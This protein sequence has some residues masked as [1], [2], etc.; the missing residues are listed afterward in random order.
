MRILF[1]IILPVLIFTGLSAREMESFNTGWNFQLDPSQPH[2]VIQSGLDNGTSRQVDLPHDWS[3]EGPYDKDNPA[4]IR[5][6]FLP[7]GIGFYSKSFFW[8]DGW[9]G[10]R[11]FIEFDGVFMKSDVWINGVHLGYY[12][13][14]YMGFSYDLTEQL[15]EGENLIVVKA[16]NSQLPSSRWYTGSG[17]YR[18]VRLVSTDPVHVKQWGTFIRS[19]PIRENLAEW[20]CSIEVRND[21]AVTQKLLLKTSVTGPDGKVVSQSETPF[22]AKPGDN[23]ITQN[24]IISAPALWSVDSPHLY[25]AH[26]KIMEDGNIL[27]HY[28]TRF[29]IRS[30]DFSKERGFLLNGKPLLIK[31]V[32]NHH[33]GGPVGS[34][35]PLDVLKYRLK[36]LKEMGCNA[37]RTAHNP[38]A[39]EFYDL[40]DEMGFLV[41]DEAFD[42]WDIP[43]AEYDYGHFFDEWWKVDLGSLIRRDRNHPSVIIWSIGNEVPQFTDEQQKIMVDFVKALDDTRPVTQGRGYRGP[44]IDLAGFNG[45][46]EE[47]GKLENVSKQEHRPIIGTEITHSLQTR[48]V[49]R[50]RSWIRRRDAPAP[51]EIGKDFKNMEHLVTFIPDFTEEEVFTQHSP[52][53]QS[54]YDNAI[55]R[56]GVRDDWKRVEKYPWYL[57]NFR[58][59]GFDYLGESFGWPARTENFGIIDLA[60]FP[61]DH[62][63]LYQSL[64][65]D[66]PMVHVLP[67]WTHPGKED[68]EI[69]VVV[70]TNCPE[71]E[72]FLNGQ[73]LGRKEMTGERQLVW[74]VPYHPGT[75]QAVAYPGE[76]G[77]LSKEFQTAGPAAEVKLGANRSSV[78]ANGTDV[79]RIEASIT[80]ASG[81]FC[82]S[83]DHLVEFEISGPAKLLAVENGDILDTSP[84]QVN[85]RK[86]FK[87]KCLL[88]LQTTRESGIIQVVGKSV[89]LKES[90][91][92]LESFQ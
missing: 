4:G 26:F 76:G 50:T 52:R 1:L 43:K 48:G 21:E 32:C 77:T 27:D 78:R 88:L 15:R 2:R 12:P 65:S 35:V 72:L 9:K 23:V 14:G 13:Y 58:W 81:N 41:M 73:S 10:K 33:D 86:A 40:C 28:E 24:G 83:A 70:Y 42:G 80:D 63:Y 49:Y 62:Y 54:G 47:K 68:T 45:H 36:L 11:V 75:L 19:R 74:M 34:A 18:N 90:R 39:P 84:H 91:V 61:K 5:G 53:Y 37:I 59:T 71:A 46:G 57:G 87:G 51:W 17:I 31:G 79:V 22:E 66:K 30:I 38:L 20:D 25:T 82:P 92:E 60:G 67:H 69:P 85:T 3:I 7:G 8:R 64:W 44:W 55:V 56:I 29:G 16:D 6:A 89:G